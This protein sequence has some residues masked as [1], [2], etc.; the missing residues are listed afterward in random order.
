MSCAFFLATL[1]A[2]SLISKA[3]TS[4]ESPRCFFK[5]TAIAPLPVHK[6]K[7][8]IISSFLDVTLSLG[9]CVFCDSASWFS[10]LS[11]CLESSIS[12]VFSA[13]S[14]KISVSGCGINTFSFTKNLSP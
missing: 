9:I 4:A 1:S 6:S 8:L 10:F 11:D 3:S 13:F 2:S 5:Q 14:T 12:A 7:I